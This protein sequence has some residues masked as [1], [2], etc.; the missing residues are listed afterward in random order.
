MTSDNNFDA[1]MSAFA[2]ALGQALSEPVE[3]GPVVLS[4]DGTEVTFRE[5]ADGAAIVV[6]AE[7]GEMPSDDRGVFSSLALQANFV[8][9]GGS[10]LS[11]DA[12]TGE[13]FVATSL[14]FVQADPDTLSDA[15]E[16]LVNVAEEWRYH[17]VAFLDVDEEAAIAKAD[18]ADAN[19]LSGDPGFL[20]V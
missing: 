9:G 12:E 16:S 6:A 14:P 8:A 17:A 1:C 2:G 20:R 15:V 13:L 11:L 5:S 18:E 3:N 10:A 4:I 7:I 19:P